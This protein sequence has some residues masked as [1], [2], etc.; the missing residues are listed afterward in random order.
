MNKLGMKYHR[1]TVG[2]NCNKCNSDR[3]VYSI[4]DNTFGCV[5][6]GHKKKLTDHVFIKVLHRLVKKETMTKGYSHFYMINLN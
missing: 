1:F 5:D 4:E 2:S 3:T 6:C